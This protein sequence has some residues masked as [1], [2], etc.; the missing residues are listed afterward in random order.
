MF[1]FILTKLY[2]HLPFQMFPNRKGLVKQFLKRS[3]QKKSTGISIWTAWINPYAVR[4]TRLCLHYSLWHP[5]CY[6]ASRV[7][8]DERTWFLMQPCF[9]FVE[10]K[11][12]DNTEKQAEQKTHSNTNTFFLH[13]VHSQGRGEILEAWFLDRQLPDE[14]F[15]LFF[16]LFTR[17]PSELSTP[18]TQRITKC[19]SVAIQSLCQFRR[20]WD[21]Q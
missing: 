14:A 11:R 21:S 6:T 3:D 10:S 12:R 4:F 9:F 16:T 20:G 2:F 8:S 7:L 15:S 5:Y 18:L 13:T 19:F 1:L 17:C